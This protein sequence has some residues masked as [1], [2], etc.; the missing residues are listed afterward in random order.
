MDFS[1]LLFA[2]FLVPLI[3]TLWLFG[4]SPT[5]SPPPDQ[6]KAREEQYFGAGNQEIEPQ[7]LQAS[8]NTKSKYGIPDTPF[9]V[10]EFSALMH[11]Y[12]HAF[13][14]VGY[15][16]PA[17]IAFPPH[18]NINRTLCMELN[19][20]P[21]VIDLI[22]NIPFPMNDQESMISPILEFSQALVFTDDEHLLISR[23]PEHGDWD[24]DMRRLTHI[25]P[26]ELP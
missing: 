2:A 1:E 9:S 11:D 20:D 23:D 17:Q 14:A 16:S 22:E 3:A 21:I 4:T 7:S 6:R 24:P 15:V 5:P 19:L 18:N 12:Y 8:G 26:W 13:I 25:S 10:P